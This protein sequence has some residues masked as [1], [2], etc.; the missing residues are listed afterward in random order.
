M[1]LIL[2]LLFIYVTYESSGGGGLSEC[3]FWESHSNMCCICRNIP[4]DPKKKR[5][6]L[7]RAIEYSEESRAAKW[8]KIPSVDLTKIWILSIMIWIAL[9]LRELT[10]KGKCKLCAAISFSIRNAFYMIR[11][12]QILVALIT[13]MYLDTWYL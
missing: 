8:M 12:Q 2:I 5:M 10:G 4:G 6:L 3:M 7:E 1:L 9:R 13:K 11:W